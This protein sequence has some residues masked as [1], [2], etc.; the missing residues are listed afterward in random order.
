[1][2]DPADRL[3]SDRANRDAARSLFDARLA[4]LRGALAE[5]GIGGRIKDQLSSDARN[6][7]IKAVDIAESQ[8]GVVAGTAAALAVWFLRVPIMAWVSNL[9][10]HDDKD[11]HSE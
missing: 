7:F 9:V 2:A 5:R 10:A 3:D 1:M 6:G 8:K 11:Q 4:N